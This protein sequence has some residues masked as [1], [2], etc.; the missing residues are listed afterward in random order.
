MTYL[1]PEYY[2]KKYVNFINAIKEKYPNRNKRFKHSEKHHIIP[3]K[4]YKCESKINIIYLT[5]REHFIAHK[6]LLM[7]FPES[8]Q[9]QSAYWC[10]SHTRKGLRITSK[11]YERG[12]KLCKK[13]LATNKGKKFSKEHREKIGAKNK[14]RKHTEE[15]KKEMSRIQK[16]IDRS[17]VD[18]TNWNKA[19][20]KA[21]AIKKKGM[22][23]RNNGLIEKFFPKSEPIEFGWKKGRLKHKK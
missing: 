23:W 16:Q 14:G 5:P 19:G 6:F 11:D 18:Y 2:A 21:A 10:M 17:H 7:A 20:V 3:K 12:K 22:E 9:I 8:T 15:Q 4:I 1:T 13:A